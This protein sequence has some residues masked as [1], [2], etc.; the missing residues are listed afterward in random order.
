MN[1]TRLGRDAG[2]IAQEVLAHLTGLKDANVTVTVEIQAQLP[3]G[4][5]QPTVRTV[6]ENCRVLKFKSHGFEQA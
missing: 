5:D 4:V 6:T 1:P 2:R 3:E